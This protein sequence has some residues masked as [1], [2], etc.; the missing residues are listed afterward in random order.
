M[1]FIGKTHLAYATDVLNNA[2]F[3]VDTIDGKSVK[4]IQFPVRFLSIPEQSL[5]LPSLPS[6]CNYSFSDEDSRACSHAQLPAAAAI[7]GGAAQTLHSCSLHLVVARSQ[8][9]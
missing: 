6:P 5:H 2:L 4:V 8:S 7:A 9:L 3:L 1:Q